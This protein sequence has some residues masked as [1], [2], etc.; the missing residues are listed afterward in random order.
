MAQIKEL[1]LGDPLAVTVD[2]LEELNFYIARNTSTQQDELLFIGTIV[3]PDT[4]KLYYTIDQGEQIQGRLFANI[5][6][7][8]DSFRHVTSFVTIDVT[9]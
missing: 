8:Y 7:N 4:N 5:G 1:V 9:E 2:E 6:Q 3:A